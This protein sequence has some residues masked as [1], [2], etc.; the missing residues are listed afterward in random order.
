[1]GSDPQS[2]SQLA[3]FCAAMA[4]GVGY[5]HSQQLMAAAAAGAGGIAKR[6]PIVLLLPSGGMGVGGA[7]YCT[8]YAL[9][10]STHLPAPSKFGLWRPGAE[11]SRAQRT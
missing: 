4:F 11:N 7:G 3:R 6:G 8:G 9:D 5:H 2:H 1:M 10:Y